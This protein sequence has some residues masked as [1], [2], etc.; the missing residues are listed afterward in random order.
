MAST[1]PSFVNK[2]Y[3]TH[4]ALYLSSLV[5][6]YLVRHQVKLAALATESTL[7]KDFLQKIINQEVT[8]LTREQM[9]VLANLLGIPVN[10]V[11]LPGE[12]TKK[13]D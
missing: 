4:Y 9:I 13:R 12:I 1:R 3:K 11:I 6:N 7:T 10:A 5:R 8:A 2:D